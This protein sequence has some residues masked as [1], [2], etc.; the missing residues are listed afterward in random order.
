MIVFDTQRTVSMYQSYNK[1]VLVPRPPPR[2]AT[3]Q[4]ITFWDLNRSKDI[5]IYSYRHRITD[6]DPFTD[7]FLTAQ[8]IKVNPKEPEP[9]DQFG[10]HR[11]KVCTPSPR[12]TQICVAQFST[13]ADFGL[14]TR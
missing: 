14:C 8:G 1:F 3:Q 4:H 6:C 9:K 5:M 2:L 13:Y 10:E 12:V 7:D 11:S